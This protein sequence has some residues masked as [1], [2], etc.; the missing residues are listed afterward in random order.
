MS[1]QPTSRS[2]ALRVR[3]AAALRR[4]EIEW[5]VSRRALGERAPAG[6]SALLTL[7]YRGDVGAEERWE[8]I[9]PGSGAS[10][11]VVPAGA[12]GASV[13]EIRSSGGCVHVHSATI[14]AFISSEHDRPELLYA[15]TPIFASL[16]VGGGRYQPQEV[17]LRTAP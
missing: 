3:S 13:P 6:D 14:Y 16:R 9:D 2:G 5:G 17:R 4:V 11:P 7:R 15:R 8:L 12:A 10:V 1:A